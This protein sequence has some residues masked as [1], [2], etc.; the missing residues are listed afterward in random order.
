MTLLVVQYPES[1]ITVLRPSLAAART[2]A[3]TSSRSAWS[4]MIADINDADV[5]P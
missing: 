5:S 2:A 3:A 1:P 4:F